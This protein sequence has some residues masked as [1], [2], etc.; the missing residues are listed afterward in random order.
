MSNDAANVIMLR[1]KPAST[2]VVQACKLFMDPRSCNLE[3]E[4]FDAHHS[5]IATAVYT[6]I[7]TIPP[8][9]D[10]DEL[11]SYWD[12]AGNSGTPAAS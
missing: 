6:F 8:M 4:L 10:L 3:V 9:F 11:R 7:G 12:R 5:H 2:P 1:P